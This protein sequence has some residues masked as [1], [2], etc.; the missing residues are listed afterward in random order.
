MDVGTLEYIIPLGQ[1]PNDG[2]V[3]VS[4]EQLTQLQT[5]IEQLG[6]NATF[7]YSTQYREITNRAA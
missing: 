2:V 6:N 3:H 1:L 5:A 4:R 7:Q